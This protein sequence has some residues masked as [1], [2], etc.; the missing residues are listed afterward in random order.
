VRVPAR[1]AGEQSASLART[2][3]GAPESE[4][5]EVALELV[6]TQV[7]IVLG[8]TSP[9]AIDPQ[10]TFKELGF[11]SL[12]AVE[13][14]NRLNA[15]TGLQLSATLVFDHP[16]ITTITSHLLDQIVHDRTAAPGDVELQRL[17]HVLVSI[18]SDG[19]ERTR[20]TGRLQALIAQLGQPQPGNGDVAVSQKIDMASDDELFKYLDERAYAAPAV[21]TQ[22]LDSS[23]ERERN[24]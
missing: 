11:D 24:D 10:R 22:T 6:R 2:L 17:E 23:E 14:R 1:R 12:A 4:R 20:I 13:L 16:T 19:S 8:H 21:H 18:A 3:A 15:V 5:Q 9:D 7:A